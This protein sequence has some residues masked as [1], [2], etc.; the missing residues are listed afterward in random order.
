MLENHTIDVMGRE[1]KSKARMRRALSRSEEATIMSLC[2]EIG[3]QR[4]YNR[5]CLQSFTWSELS[6]REQQ[7]KSSNSLFIFA[8]VRGATYESME[9]QARN[10]F[11]EVYVDLT[12]FDAP[13]RRENYGFGWTNLRIRKPVTLLFNKQSRMKSLRS[14]SR[15]IPG[16]LEAQIYFNSVLDSLTLY[17]AHTDYGNHLK[18]ISRNT[19]KL[20]GPLP[21]AFSSSLGPL[22][23]SAFFLVDDAAIDWH[24]R[25]PHILYS[26]FT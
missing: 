11:V 26:I 16:V 17:S 4:L 24:D 21:A 12:T 23:F 13:A 1:T 18:P 9:K 25:K 10:L 19:K 22:I 3:L 5:V 8:F 6:T 20:I 2:R 7:P 14:Y 15:L